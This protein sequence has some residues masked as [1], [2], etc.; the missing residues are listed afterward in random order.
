MLRL[1][2]ARDC[3]AFRLELYLLFGV[4][5]ACLLGFKAIYLDDKP[6]CVDSGPGIVAPSLFWAMLSVGVSGGSGADVN[7]CWSRI[8]SG[9]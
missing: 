3:M 6:A 9:C 7:P 2:F 4:M 8:P 5:E 1:R